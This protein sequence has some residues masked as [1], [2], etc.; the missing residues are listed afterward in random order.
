MRTIFKYPVPITDRFS[1]TMPGAIKVLPAEV[2]GTA[3]ESFM[4]V[5]VDPEGAEAEH[6]FAVVGTGGMIP[7]THS[8]AAGGM[9]VCA[10][11]LKTWQAPPFVWHLY[12]IFPL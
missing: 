12:R 8:D 1:V 9:V 7:S 2:Q 6:H 10:D 3:S 5:E 11:H 4:W